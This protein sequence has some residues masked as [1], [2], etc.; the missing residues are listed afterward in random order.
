MDPETMLLT[1]P[2][3]L[4]SVVPYF[5]LLLALLS[6]LMYW[7]IT[8][9]F[10]TISG[11]W[12]FLSTSDWGFSR[13]WRSIPMPPRTKSNLLLSVL[14]MH[15]NYFCS[16]VW[17][18]LWVLVNGTWMGI[19]CPRFRHDLLKTSPAQSSLLFHLLWIGAK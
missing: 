7:F 6:S 5:C 9:C 10:Q 15:L 18:T 3:R 16:C 11:C 1:S 4:L 2:C 14:Y 17:S 13:F 12:Y 19:M 8:T